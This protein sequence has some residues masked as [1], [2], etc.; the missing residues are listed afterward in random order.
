MTKILILED[1]ENNLRLLKK[2]V[3]R[4]AG[5]IEIETA[6]TLAEAREQLADQRNFF[7]AFFLDINLNEKK[8]DDRSGFLFAKEIRSKKQYLFT[9]VIM[10]TSI[11]NL[12]L[13]AYRELH[14]YQYILKPFEETEI[15]KLMKKLLTQAGEVTD[16]S[17]TVKKDGINYKISCKDMVYI[18]AIPRGISIVMPREEMKVPYTSLKQ[19]MEKLPKE[20]F[21][22]CHR[23]YVVNQDYIDYV[24]FVNGIIKLTVCG[25]I[26][27]GVTHKNEVRERLNG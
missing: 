27:I 18:K 21:V 5:E 24:D 1:D 26:E 8:Q 20:Q 12:E 10:I 6:L 7:H 13:Q 14:C 2:M 11:A 15:R 17:V 4:A 23:M 25:E 9:P 22:Q 3:Q 16:T 19:V